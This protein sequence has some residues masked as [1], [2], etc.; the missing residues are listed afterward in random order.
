MGALWISA[1]RQASRRPPIGP[2]IARAIEVRASDYIPTWLSATTWGFVALAILAQAALGVLVVQHHSDAAHVAAALI[3][4]GAP[5]LALTLSAGVSYRWAVRRT[6]ATH[7]DEIAGIGMLSIV[8]LFVAWR[9]E[10]GRTW[11]HFVHRLWPDG[12]PAEAHA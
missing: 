2:R 5:L 7:L 8:F 4:G 6:L 12:V 9:G 10:L 1:L 11:R 3:G